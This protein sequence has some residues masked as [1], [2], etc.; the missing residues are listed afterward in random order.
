MQGDWKFDPRWWPDPEGMV[1]ELRQQ[2]VELMV[3]VWPTVD[4]R[5]ANY[6]EMLERGFLTRAERGIPHHHGLHG[7]T[8]CSTMP[9]TPRPGI[10]SGGKAKENYWDKGIRI[11][12][13]DVAE[14]EYSVY[15]FDHYRYQ[16][17]SCREVGN[18]YPLAYAQTFHDGMRAQGQEGVINLLPARG[19]QPALRRAGVVSEHRHHVGI[20][21]PAARRRPQ[22]GPGGHPLVDHRHRRIPGRRSR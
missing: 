18:I 17:G 14:P 19:R 8:P 16:L 9:P 6:R 21:P 22:H 13:L 5:S 10:S 20:L 7:Q 12:W 4:K 2:G 1:R 11:F 3:S 15:D